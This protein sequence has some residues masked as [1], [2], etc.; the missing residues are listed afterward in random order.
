MRIWLEHRANS[1]W[2]L[3]EGGMIRCV[4]H[5]HLLVCSRHKIT[6]LPVDVAFALVTPALVEASQHENQ[7]SRA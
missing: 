3:K 5:D 7:D 2:Q 6:T 1:R 4:Y